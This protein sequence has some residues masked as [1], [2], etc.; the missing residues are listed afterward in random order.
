MQ[1][2]QRRGNAPPRDKNFKPKR[3]SR[4]DFYVKGNPSAVAVPD[5][6]PGTLEKAL[7]YFKRQQKDSD[8]MAKYRDNTEYTK[9]SAK[10]RVQKEEAIRN[11]QYKNKMEGR[12]EKG[13]VWTAI[14]D[15]DAQ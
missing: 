6:K 10:R 4:Q 15:G 9:P 12:R 7:R 5:S 3:Y 13:Y 2:E 14:L 1:K 11:E 8:V